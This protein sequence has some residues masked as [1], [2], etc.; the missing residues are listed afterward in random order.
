[1][2][3]RTYSKDINVGQ[4]AQAL[5]SYFMAQGYETQALGTPPNMLVQVR[6]RGVIRAVAGMQRVMSAQF[7]ET[8][9]GILVTLG[10]QKWADKAAVGAVGALIFA[11]LIVT[12]AY[13]AY[14][15]AKLPEQFW[16]IIDNMAMPAGTAYAVPPPGPQQAAPQTDLPPA[17]GT[18]QSPQIPKFCPDCGAPQHGTHF[19]PNCGRRH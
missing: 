13:G 18:E 7:R 10:E 16:Q 4:I 14:K 12:A 6:K 2:E 19:C 8:Q 3:Q 11:P 1:M 5:Q 9:E 17:A 15:Q